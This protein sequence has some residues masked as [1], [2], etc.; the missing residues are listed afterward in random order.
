VLDPPCLIVIGG[1]AVGVCDIMSRV[2]VQSRYSSTLCYSLVRPSPR[3]LRS[4]EPWEFARWWRYKIKKRPLV[5][6]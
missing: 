3:P 4:I 2:L 6:L 1:D 5:G